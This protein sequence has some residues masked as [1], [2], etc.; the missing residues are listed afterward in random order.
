MYSNGAGMGVGTD[1]P[2]YH[3]IRRLTWKPKV[4]N[5]YEYA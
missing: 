5:H 3:I 1:H 2:K 4:S